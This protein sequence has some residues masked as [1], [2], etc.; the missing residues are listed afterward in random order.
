MLFMRYAW[1]LKSLRPV[2]R[3]ADL[4]YILVS[5]LNSDVLPG[6]KAGYRGALQAGSMD[7]AA[8]VSELDIYFRNLDVRYGPASK[9]RKVNSLKK[10]AA[11]DGGAGSD[12]KAKKPHTASH[13]GVSGANKFNTTTK[14]ECYSWVKNGTCRFG[15]TEGGCR[16]NH[17]VK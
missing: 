8:L 3:D 12:H 2:T 5:S 7:F 13:N 14:E 15:K 10:R 1:A 9:D 4:A 16:F 17:P 11:T 6:A